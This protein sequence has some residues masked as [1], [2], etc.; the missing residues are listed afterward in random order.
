MGSVQT[1]RPVF[2][3][4]LI[5]LLVVKNYVFTRQE[6]EDRN[7]RVR[8]EPVF[9][10]GRQ[11]SQRTQHTT[12]IST[13]SQVENELSLLSLNKKTLDG[14]I[15]EASQGTPEP[16]EPTNTRDVAEFEQSASAKSS[17]R[18]VQQGNVPEA[19]SDPRKGDSP[20]QK[21]ETP[22]SIEPSVSSKAIESEAHLEPKN[23]T[24][25]TTIVNERKKEKSA[26]QTRAVKT[27][28]QIDDTNVTATEALANTLDD[29]P[30]Q[31]TKSSAKVSVQT[32]KTGKKATKSTTK[33]RASVIPNVLIA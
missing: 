29:K 20:S 19:L 30:Q 5:S 32:K 6:I 11:A 21:E 10:P 31:R 26:A 16:D 8:T 1:Q 2:F 7:L 27:E 14:K 3:L 13:L 18:E 33:P 15:D 25:G 12:L 22:A 28:D 24:S 9:R 4:V 23:Q 17:E